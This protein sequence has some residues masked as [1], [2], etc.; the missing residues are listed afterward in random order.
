M[1]H[2]K[3]LAALVLSAATAPAAAA[4]LS[5]MFYAGA[6]VGGAQFDLG[7]TEDALGASLAGALA[8]PGTVGSGVDADDLSLALGAQLGYQITRYIGVELSYR[9]YGDADASWRTSNGATTQENAVEISASGVGIGLLGYLPLGETANLFL[10]VDAVNLKTRVEQLAVDTA[11]PAYLH[12]SSSESDIAT[13]LGL[14]LQYN[15][16]TCSSLRIEASYIEAELPGTGAAASWP[17]TSLTVGFLK[18]F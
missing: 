15:F 17:I 7:E 8:V 13:G 9:D 6:A 11:V 2:R 18:S 10:R 14:G 3:L 12:D 5:Q 1:T 16:E 4:D